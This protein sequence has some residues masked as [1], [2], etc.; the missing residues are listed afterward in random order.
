MS[1]RGAIRVTSQ[2]IQVGLAHARKVVT[3]ELHDTVLRIID[4]DGDILKVVPRTTT[5]EAIQHK[6]HRRDPGT[7]PRTCTGSG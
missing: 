4:D 2:R 5:K 7:R 3:L 6:A 1:V